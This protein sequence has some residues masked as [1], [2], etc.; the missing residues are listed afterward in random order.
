MR[1]VPRS[2]ASAL[3]AVTSSS[4]IRSWPTSVTHPD[5]SPPG[6]SPSSRADCRSITSAAGAAYGPSS[7]SQP[8]V[9]TVPRMPTAVMAA[10]TRSG[11]A[12]VP[13][14]TVVVTPW[15][16]ASTQARVADSSSSS[17]EWWAC[18]G[19]AQEKIDS[20]GARSSGMEQRTS[21]SP[22][23]CWWAL[24]K[25]GVTTCPGPPSTSTS[26]KWARAAATSTTPRIVP[27]ATSTAASTRIVRA[28]SIVST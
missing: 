5:T 20:P 16:T 8:H 28:G 24:T 19:T 21:R 7:T 9:P 6:G 2:W 13:A 12:T 23:R 26:G 4:D 1:L 15:V 3:A 25:P 17:G 27:P 14:S 11:W 18:T 22:V 10:A